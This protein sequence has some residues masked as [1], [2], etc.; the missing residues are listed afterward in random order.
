MRASAMASRGTDLSKI[1]KNLP[2]IL[3]YEEENDEGAMK[4][5]RGLCHDILGEIL[6]PIRYDWKNERCVCVPHDRE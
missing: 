5:C 6:C 4:A 2:V 3:G 1:K